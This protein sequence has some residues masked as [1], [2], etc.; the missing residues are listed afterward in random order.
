MKVAYLFSGQGSQYPGMGKE[1]FD[2]FDRCKKIF[3][4]ASD[5]L[6]FD[7]AKTAF[8]ADEA[9]LAKTE[10]SQGLIYTVSLCAW[11]TLIQ[12]G[13]LPLAV[14]GHSL[15]EYAALT[16]AGAFSMEDGFRIIKA[17]SHAMSEAAQQNPGCMAA[18][19][20]LTEEA[21]E[22][23]CKNTE[24][25]VQAVNYN[26]PEQTVI[27]GSIFA[28]EA[29]CEQ[30]GQMGAK[31]V[32]LAVA[33]AFHTSYMAEA[34]EKLKT[35]LQKTPL[36]PLQLPFYCNLT[37]GLINP[38]QSLPQYLAAHQVS[39]VLFTKEIDH[40]LADGFDTFIELGPNKV[41]TMLLKKGWRG[42]C[43][44]LNVENQ[45]TLEKAL[46]TL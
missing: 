31:T 6:G 37:G 29:A 14:A 13:K 12:H 27:A 20:G 46:E 7:A 39:P 44:A 17:R 45:K 1:F 18:V 40:M 33:S 30:F 26:S 28:V 4:C 35:V 3:Q 10:I 41:L 24:G 32:R 43:T 15:G 16:C 42:R 22:E 21:V 23:V 25:F 11:D 5:I 9:T 36:Q 2:R 8:E 34:A 19:I 38:E